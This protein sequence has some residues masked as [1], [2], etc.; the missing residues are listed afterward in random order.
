MGK[1]AIKIKVLVNDPLKAGEF[2]EVF[3]Q[4]VDLDENISFDYNLVERTFRLLF[5]SCLVQI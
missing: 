2:K 4:V 1:R 5:P 3:R